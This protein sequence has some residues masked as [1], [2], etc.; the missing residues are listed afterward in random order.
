MP[1]QAGAAYRQVRVPGKVEIEIEG[2]GVKA[3]NGI[4]KA[5]AG[6]HIGFEWTGYGD[7]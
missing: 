4:E 6:E 3:E 1:D 5:H 7:T 2:I